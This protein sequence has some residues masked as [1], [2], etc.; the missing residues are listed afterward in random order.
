MTLVQVLVNRQIIVLVMKHIELSME[1][2]G[3]N[4]TALPST[5]DR[6]YWNSFNKVQ[7]TNNEF[8]S[9]IDTYTIEQAVQD[10]STVESFM[11][12]R[13]TGK[14]H[15]DSRQSFWWIFLR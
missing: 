6:I 13:S 15:S 10:G 2:L 1:H 8:G 11:K 3:N 12:E 14:S 5:E 4:G 7:Q 9:Y